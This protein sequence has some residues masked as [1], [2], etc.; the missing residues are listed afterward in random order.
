MYPG[1]LKTGGNYYT[2]VTGKNGRQAI[3]KTGDNVHRLYR[4]QETK[5]PHCTENKRQNN[6]TVKKTLDKKTTL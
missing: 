3:Q 4:K 5:Y 2:Q 6:H 1:W